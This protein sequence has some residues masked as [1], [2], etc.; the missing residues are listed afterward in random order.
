[1]NV[2]RA[3]VL[4]LIGCS[5]FSSLAAAAADPAATVD[6][7]AKIRDFEQVAISPDGTQVA[8]VE[9]LNDPNGAASRNT[10]LYCQTRQGSA[11]HPKRI[12][13][14]A[15]RDAKEHNIA[16]APD[17]KHLAFLSD[18]EHAG[19]A[20]LYITDCA[21][22]TPKRVSSFTGYLDAP[23]WS[24]DGKHIAVLFTE[25][26]SVGS[27]PLE[28][29]P[30]RVGKI[31]D[32]ISEQRI[33]II[34]PDT[35]KARIVSPADMYI[36]EYDW[37]PDGNTFVV[38]SA[39]GS[40]ENNWWIAQLY[41]LSASDGRMKSIYKPSL[42]I[43][44][45]RWSPDGKSIA[46]IH[47][48][49]S[50]EASTGGDIY[51]ISADGGEPRNVTPQ[52]HGSA[53]WLTWTGGQ[54][55][56]VQNSHGKTVLSRVNPANASIQDLWSA[57]EFLRSGQWMGSVSVANDGN[58]IAAV[59]SSFSQ[60]PQVVAGQS[61]ALKPITSPNS[62][63]PVPWG[64]TESVAWK[65][66]QFDVQGWLVFPQPYDPAKKYPL[67]VDVHGGPA[68]VVST[69][70]P[71]KH[72][73]L[74][75]LLSSQGYFVFLPNP[76]GSYGQGEDF[77]KANVKDYG[78]GDLRDIMRGIDAVI[79]KYPVDEKRLGVTGWSYGGFMTMW[80]VTQTNR[81]AA[82]VAGAGLANWQSYYGQN[83]IDQWMIPYFGASVYDDPAVYA[84]SSP[85]TFIKQAKTPTLVVVGQY[86]AECPSPQSFEFWHALK[87]LNVPTSMIVYPGEGHEFHAPANRRDVNVQMIGWFNKYLN[88]SGT[89]S[90]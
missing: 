17:S 34:D 46:F 40:G 26:S 71:G 64:K 78:Y 29:S 12:S 11:A 81:F 76:R 55:M 63:A 75:I 61:G 72:H 13:V 57:E 35:A 20:Q 60:P 23:L 51:V 24:P 25:G 4:L 31:E 58:T 62:S 54:I 3:V 27:D 67:V 44:I 79:S 5:L 73:Y 1:M 70:F 45:P 88:P 50:D 56:F 65:S 86:D 38:S 28:A 48:L 8:W 9:M 43:A 82:A 90:H 32:E 6:A 39:S 80:T 59:H 47:G 77:T 87:T 18:A 2:L 85:I 14:A 15:G 52:L 84:K 21:G 68:S 83:E 19:Q 89:T 66:D 74:P 37:S 69:A 49:M 10:A 30:P 7:L 41:T 53:S 22:S 33:A 36:Y 16:W 42:Q